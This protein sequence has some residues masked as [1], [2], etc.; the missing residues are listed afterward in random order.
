MGGDY[1]ERTCE[2]TSGDSMGTM[3]CSIDVGCGE[4]EYECDEY[5]GV[6]TEECD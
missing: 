4:V 2:I 5:D 1:G 6:R 3:S